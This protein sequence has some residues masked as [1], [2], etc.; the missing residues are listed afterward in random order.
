M[1]YRK[2]LDVLHWQWQTCQQ[3]DLGVR[4]VDSGG[5]FV[6]GE[7]ATRGILFIGEGPGKDEEREG[8][9]FVGE[10]GRILRFAIK[11]LGLT[12]V[13]LT[14]AVACR[15]AEH[16]HTGEGQPIYNKDRRTGEQKAYIRD[17]PPTPIQLDACSPRLKE[18]IYL[19]DPVLIVTL[20]GEA[21]KAVTGSAPHIMASR[22]ATQ[23][24][25]IEGA[26]KVP[27]TTE[28]KKTW[29]RKVQGEWTLPTKPN[30]V[31]YSVLPTFHPSF[32]LRNQA[33]KRPN[34][35]TELFTQDMMTVARIYDRYM[36]EAYGLRPGQRSLNPEDIRTLIGED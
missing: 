29:A 13:Y 34:N 30:K 15:A 7:G 6:F 1:D 36:L 25:E 8:R 10:S 18:Q 22:G 2:T 24:I 3:C 14:N 19:V 28:K 32:V 26:W 4:R 17:A 27:A 33:D 11:Q 21:L 20:G 31:R 9:P 5:A 16:A 12:N 23:E 35:P